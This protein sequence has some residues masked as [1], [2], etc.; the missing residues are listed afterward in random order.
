MIKN[1][2]IFVVSLFLI[3]ACGGG[4]SNTP[5]PTPDSDHDGII[6]SED[7]CVNTPNA[8]QVDSDNDGIGDICDSV[9]NTDNTIDADNNNDNGTN[10]YIRKDGGTLAQCD[11]LHDKA[12]DGN[13]NQCAWNHPWLVI[14]PKGSTNNTDFKGGDT[15]IIG[16]G[17]YTVG[18]GAIPSSR[19]KR[20]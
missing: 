13:S 3:S 2:L 8:D 12:F 20:L 17:K 6:N 10:F 15:L 16:A 1:S 7:N 5:E 19:N 9:D 18:Y 4:K 11:G 14:P